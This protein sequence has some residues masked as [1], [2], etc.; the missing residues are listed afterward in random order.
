MLK[1]KRASNEPMDLEHIE[2]MQTQNPD[3]LIKITNIP[4]ENVKIMG[5]NPIIYLDMPCQLFYPKPVLS[6]KKRVTLPYA[7]KKKTVK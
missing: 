6:I 1:T 2:R 3:K 4:Y 5:K 7:N